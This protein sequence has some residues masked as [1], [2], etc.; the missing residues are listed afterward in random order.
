MHYDATI[1]VRYAETDQMGIVY[2]SNY[3][4]WFEEARTG[5]FEAVMGMTYRELEEQGVYFPLTE[6]GCRYRSPA[7]YADE[8][9]VRARIREVKG[10]CVTIAYEA[11]LKPEMKL[12]AEGW[13]RHVFVGRELRPVNFQR[14]RPDMYEMMRNAAEPKEGRA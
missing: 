3:F 1:R 2:H 13:T 5:L 10:P 9:S 11:Y 8:L 12:L 6:C 7:R 14:L 4:P